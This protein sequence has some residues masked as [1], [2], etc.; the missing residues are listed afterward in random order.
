MHRYMT[1]TEYYSYV[2]RRYA[3]ILIE[4]QYYDP[5]E[6]TIS[7]DIDET[8]LCDLSELPSEFAEYYNLSHIYH[9]DIIYIRPKIPYSLHFVNSINDMGFIIHFITAREPHRKEK[10]LEDIADFPYNYLHFYDPLLYSNCAIFKKEMRKSHNCI[11]IGDQ[12]YDVD[13]EKF[14]IRNPFY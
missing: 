11:G 9:D 14:L 8:I 5:K 4:L 3:E 2:R 1:A 7:L 13:D 6:Y 10:T 12:P